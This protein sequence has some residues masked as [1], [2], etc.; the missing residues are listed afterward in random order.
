MSPSLKVLIVGAGIAGNA[1]AVW[2]S[3]LGNNV[4][5]IERYS[6]LRVNGLQLDLRGHGIDVMKRMG[7]EQ[8]VRAKCVPES[9]YCWIWALVYNTFTNIPTQCLCR[10]TRAC[11]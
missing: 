11:R 8:T 5:V 4:T 9:K 6:I 7:L 3:K 10:R 2:L 1:L